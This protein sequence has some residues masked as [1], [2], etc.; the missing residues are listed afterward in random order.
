MGDSGLG[1]LLG[2]SL[3]NTQALMESDKFGDSINSSFQRGAAGAND[4][5]GGTDKALLSNRES[6][7]LL[8]EE[9]GIHL[10]RAVSGAIAEMMP[11]INMIGGALLGVFAVKMAEEFGAKVKDIAEKFDGVAA[12][13]RRAQQ[14]GK[15]NLTLLDKEVESNKKLLMGELTRAQF[16]AVADEAEINAMKTKALRQLEIFGP[17][18]AGYMAIAGAIGKL[19]DAQNKL[20]ADQQLADKMA[21]ILRKDNEEE[22]KAA[23]KAAEAAEKREKAEEKA[24]KY[25]I[26]GPPLIA[27]HTRMAQ[28]DTKAIVQW[29]IAYTEYLQTLQKL[30]QV[31]PMVVLDWHKLEV[32]GTQVNYVLK[33]QVSIIKELS[34]A[35]ESDTAASIASATEGLALLVGGRKAQAAVEA[36]WETARGVACLAEGA[37]PPNPAAIA[38]AAL[39]FEA[40]A[41]YGIMAGLLAVG[42]PQARAAMAALTI[43]AAAVNMAWLHLIP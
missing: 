4:A 27:W 2:L 39:H 16:R 10:P 30:P 6:V 34:K 32:A 1:L 15:E 37:W 29:N 24:Q 5:L 33:T 8:S 36:I 23:E 31:L 43:E 12:A 40:A 21:V 28:A 20:T 9:A 42:A 41:Q 38:A 19:T 7:R 18:A 3:D 26:D 25:L 35:I 14:V 17:Y 11:N 22:A 13:E